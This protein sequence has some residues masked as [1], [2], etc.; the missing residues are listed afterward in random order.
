[1]LDW[2]RGDGAFD[3]GPF[4]IVALH[5]ADGPTGIVALEYISS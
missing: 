4:F 5:R 1:M 2:A 3:S